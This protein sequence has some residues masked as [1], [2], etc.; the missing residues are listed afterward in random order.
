MT[1]RRARIVLLRDVLNAVARK[2]RVT[3]SQLIFEA[4][5]SSAIVYKVTDMLTKEG[6]LTIEKIGDREYYF[7]I[8]PKGKSVL[9]RIKNL[10]KSLPQ[11]L[12]EYLGI[13]T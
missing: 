3:V 5:T 8:T 13:K 1:P 6:I 11:R 10:Q 12:N 9:R 7:V 2:K 4:K